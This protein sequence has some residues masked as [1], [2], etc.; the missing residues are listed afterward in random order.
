MES[1]PRWSKDTRDAAMRRRW[2]LFRVKAR[3]E[4]RR[5]F[6]S[7]ARHNHRDDALA[8]LM[9][10]LRARGRGRNKR[11]EI[12][13]GE[14]AVTPRV[15]TIL[16]GMMRVYLRITLD[17]RQTP[18]TASIPHW[19]TAEIFVKPY[20]LARARFPLRQPLVGKSERMSRG[21]FYTWTYARASCGTRT[22]KENRRRQI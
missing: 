10:E 18:F 19:Q 12:W 21:F 22:K 8:T 2:R 16:P 3:C 13:H 7:S 6:I 15:Q 4:I 9:N 1:W 14:N 20:V 11:A 5:I 17:E